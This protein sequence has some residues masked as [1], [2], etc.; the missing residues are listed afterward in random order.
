MMER[1]NPPSLGHEPNGLKVAYLHG[2][3]RGIIDMK[4]A[5]TFTRGAGQGK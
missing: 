5:Y 4:W 2:A 3:V 1:G